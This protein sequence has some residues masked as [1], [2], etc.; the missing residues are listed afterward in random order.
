M[1]R[2]VG[3]SLLTKLVTR[4]IVL[5]KLETCR[6][7]IIMSIRHAILGLLSQHPRHGYE[8]RTAFHALVGGEQVWDVKPAQIYT[9]LSR[10]ED[11]G[12]VMQAG[13]E[14]DGGP[15]KHIYSLTPQ[16]QAELS[17]WYFAGVPDEYQRDEFFLK[18]LLSLAQN[19]SASA[20]GDTVDVRRVIQSQRSIIYQKL[21]QHT[22]QRNRSDSKTE[23]AYIFLLDKAIMH[24]EAD[25]RWLDMIDARLD[26]IKRQPLPEP[27]LKVRGRP[28]K[29]QTG[30]EYP[31]P[32][33][34]Q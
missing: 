26:D 22:Q 28:R 12:Y 23:L 6:V 27:E 21:H 20:S 24:M 8:L 18:L 9:T 4:F 17:R 11:A 31:P 13:T 1:G 2:A 3:V 7:D 19:E 30:S 14:Q 32:I 10:L 25:L 33:P 34:N 29:G 5:Y 15:E 16:G